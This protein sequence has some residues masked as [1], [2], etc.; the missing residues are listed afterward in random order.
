MKSCRCLVV[1][2][3]ILS[4]SSLAQ[5]AYEG[6]FADVSVNY[7][8]WD[9]STVARSTKRDFAYLEIEGG[10]Q[11]TSGETYG[12]FDLENLA[13]GATEFRTAAKAIGRYYLGKSGF[14]LYGHVYNFTAAGFYEQN[15]VGGLGYQ[16]RFKQG[17]FNP[18]LGLHDV[19]QTF[20]Q[21]LNGYMGGWVFGYLF[22]AFGE[23]FMATN[24]HEL[25]FARAAGYASTYGGRS[26][27]HN[28]AAAI[29]WTT[30][31]GIVPGLQWR[32]AKDKLGTSGNMNAL[33]VSL[34][35]MF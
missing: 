34:K 13:K 21:G 7:L 3:L 20:Y 31:I 35:Y 12:F 26:I 30:K 27:S 8:S 33:I 25:E 6:G 17:W 11:F 16:L 1:V 24:W 10:S 22:S 4:F 32:Y 29:W 2:L 15:R 23:S 19:S 5:A 14:S 18:F 28:G 9:N